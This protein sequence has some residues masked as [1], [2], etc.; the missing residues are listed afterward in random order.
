MKHNK[1]RNTGILYELL[2]RHISSCL[3]EGKNYDAKKA[4]KIIEKRFDKSTEVYKEFRLYNAL[5]KGSVSS[6]E[7]GVAVLSEAKSAARRISTKQLEKEK[8]MLIKEINYNL[9]DKDFYYRRVA[10]YV[11]YST[12]YQLIKEWQK[13]DLGNLK[14]IIETEQKV[15]KSLMKPKKDNQLEEIKKIDSDRSNNLVYNIMTK[16]INQKYKNMD[17]DQKEI[18]KNYVFYLNENKEKLISFLT[19]K[20]HQCLNALESFESLNKNEYLS[21]KI[22]PVKEKIRSLNENACNDDEIVKFLTLTK[23]TSELISQE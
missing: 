6:I 22:Q 9:Q 11:D 3:I 19:D 12:I 15:L 23:L 7:A 10:D 4:T 5:A 14:L 20:K 1:K 2:L 17:H 13:G 21:K 18:I 16:K 8:S